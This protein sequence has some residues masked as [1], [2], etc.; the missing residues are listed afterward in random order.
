MRKIVSVFAVVLMPFASLIPHIYATSQRAYQD[1]LYQFNVYRQNYS[2][3]TITKNEYLKFKT[4]VSQTTALHATKK[5]LSQ[6]DLLL[7]AYLLL[8]NEK[9]NEDRGLSQTEKGTYQTLIANEVMF[10]ENHS[11]LVDNIGSLEDSSNVSKELESHYAVLQ[12]SMRQTIAGIS[13]GKLAVLSKNF[14]ASLEQTRILLNTSRGIFTPQKQSTIDRW[15]LQIT[16]TK[17]LYQQKVDHIVSK[18][19]QLKGSS[20]EEQ[21]QAFSQIT[22]DVAEA[23]QYL[24]EATSYLRELIEAIR[25]QD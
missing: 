16:N 19:T 21:D 24:I 4:L 12:S 8:L 2:D 15:H 10:L 1:Y 25:Y 17:S 9:L 14:D 6:R 3:F 7:R 11:R 5:M 23:R 20:I 22:K 13:L 18:N